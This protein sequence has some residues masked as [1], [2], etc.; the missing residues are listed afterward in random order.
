MYKLYWQESISPRAY[1]LKYITTLT[2]LFLD[3]SEN[4]T[5]L[6]EICLNSKTN[7]RGNTQSFMMLLLQFSYLKW[8]SSILSLAQI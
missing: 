4:I 2:E 6:T 5:I 7:A 3:T 8:Y 1:F